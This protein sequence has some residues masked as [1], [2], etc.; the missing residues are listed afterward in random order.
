MIQPVQTI[1]LRTNAVFFGEEQPAFAQTIQ[2]KFR[3][4][5]FVLCYDN[6]VEKER[7]NV[8]KIIFGS[9]CAG[10]TVH[11]FYSTRERRV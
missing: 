4:G 10:F 7:N 11:M 6:C 1:T 9:A 2:R 8:S 5:L 3:F